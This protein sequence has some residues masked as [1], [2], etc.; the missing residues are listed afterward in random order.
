MR[1]GFKQARE[2]YAKCLEHYP[3]TGV[4]L[5]NLGLIEGMEG[6]PE[7][8]KEKLEDCVRLNPRYRVGWD[9]LRQVYEFLKDS[10]NAERCRKQVESLS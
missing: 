7:A 5:L 3:D 2:C 6:K 9:M 1:A 10:K 4:A 8:A